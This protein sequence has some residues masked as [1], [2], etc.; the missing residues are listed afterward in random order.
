MAQVSEAN[1]I[2]DGFSIS[3]MGV[4]SGCVIDDRNAGGR[5]LYHSV[6]SSSR[7]FHSVMDL[8][9]FLE[10]VINLER[11]RTRACKDLVSWSDSPIHS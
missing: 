10:S 1:H 11:R 5:T 8:L 9:R 6:I 3:S 4:G 2:S 7:L